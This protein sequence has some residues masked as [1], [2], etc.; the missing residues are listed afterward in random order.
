MPD[1]TKVTAGK[2]AI[3]GAV[4]VAPL[5]TPVPESA[6]STLSAAFKEIGYC[7]DAGLVNTNT[8]SSN[9]VKAWGGD[10]VLSL[11]EDKTDT[12]KVTLIEVLNVNTLKFVFG[13]ENVTVGADGEISIDVNSKEIPAKVIVVDMIMNGGYLKRIVV[14]NGKISEIGDVTYNDS[15]AVG[16]EVT[17]D[18]L[19]SSAIDGST[20]REYIKAPSDESE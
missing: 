14:P 5:S 11:Q 18:A 13:D 12:F 3:N 2:P 19:P 17:I 15:D 20:H 9:K 10:N 4:F 8:P 1:S 16:Y 7:S 6:G